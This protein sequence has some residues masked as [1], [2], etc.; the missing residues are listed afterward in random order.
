MYPAYSNEAGDAFTYDAP[1]RVTANAIK[2]V[3][4]CADSSWLYVKLPRHEYLKGCLCY[5]CQHDKRGF[6][7]RPAWVNAEDYRPSFYRW[8]R[9]DIGAKNVR[10]KLQGGEHFVIV[11]LCDMPAFAT[12][13][14]S[15]DRHGM[16]MAM[17]WHYRNHKDAP[18][19]PKPTV[20]S[21]EIRRARRVAA[22]RL[23]TW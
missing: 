20:E 7:T 22:M 19:E 13:L 21:L 8:V 11:S 6:W 17:P 5:S 23:D 3:I 1:E 14:A 12:Q 9:V 4:G 2:R 18:A 15:H 10:L 16:L